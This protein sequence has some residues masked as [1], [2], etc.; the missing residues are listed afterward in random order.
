MTPNDV[1]LV[2]PNKPQTGMNKTRCE[3]DAK[4]TNCGYDARKSNEV[5]TAKG[6][7]CRKCN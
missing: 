7:I 3:Q 1:Q 6:Q 4:C 5:C 2:K